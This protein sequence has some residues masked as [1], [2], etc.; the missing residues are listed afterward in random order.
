M[1]RED[2]DYIFKNYYRYKSDIEKLK[3]QVI[4]WEAAA[5]K[6]TPKYGQ[7]IDVLPPRDN[8]RPSKVEAY[9]IRIARG[10]EKIANLERLIK[11]GD[12]MFAVLRPHQRYLVKRILCNGMKIKDFAKQ[13]SIHRNTV[14]KN[15]E[16]IRIES[17]LA[18]LRGILL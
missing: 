4:R 12:D 11:A 7:D 16:R 3:E 18:S 6:I 5:T 13:E 15:L 14:K 1:D 17:F 9:A 2:V 10:K 8:P